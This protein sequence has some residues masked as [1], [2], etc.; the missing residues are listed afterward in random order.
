[1]SDDFIP[2][3][4]STPVRNRWQNGN[5]QQGGYQNNWQ[6]MNHQ[7][8]GHNRKHWS[9]HSQHSNSFGVSNS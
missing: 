5:Q 7:R 4:Q 3:Y 2:L 9:N 8:R 1:M 6:H